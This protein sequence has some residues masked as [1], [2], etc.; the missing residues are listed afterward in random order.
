MFHLAAAK[1]NNPLCCLTFILDPDI[2]RG[3]ALPLQLHIVF[4]E[5]SNSTIWFLWFMRPALCPAS[6]ASPP[7]STFA[8]CALKVN[9]TPLVSL[10]ICHRHR[11][12][13]PW[14]TK[15][16][17]IKDIAL[18]RI[19]SLEISLEWLWPSFSTFV[20]G[21]DNYFM[22]SSRHSSLSVFLGVSVFLSTHLCT[23]YSLTLSAFPAKIN[24][25]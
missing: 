23:I 15:D 20:G 8:G 25:F 1:L 22:C 14:K 21:L 4:I 12:Q 3:A 17:S 2:D 6:P 13:F 11:R 18:Y 16:Q 10:H 19:K 24:N 5:E 7:I 9:L